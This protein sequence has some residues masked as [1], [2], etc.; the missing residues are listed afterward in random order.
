MPLCSCLS[1]YEFSKIFHYTNS[2]LCLN[3]NE[4]RDQEISFSVFEVQEKVITS[5]QIDLIHS[6][7]N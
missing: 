5:H 2:A 7:I 4:V 3:C 1:A 6:I